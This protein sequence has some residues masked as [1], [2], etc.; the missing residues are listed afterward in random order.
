MIFH[1]KH[2]QVAQKKVFG[3]A[4]QLSSLNVPNLQRKGP[5]HIGIHKNAFQ[6]RVSPYLAF[7]AELG[8][9]LH[10][11]VELLGRELGGQRHHQPLKAH[12][13]VLAH[14]LAK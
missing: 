7:V 11:L 4:A 8:D 3:K 6:G 9:E 12:L 14:V 13:R 10:V 2:S 1:G 5:K